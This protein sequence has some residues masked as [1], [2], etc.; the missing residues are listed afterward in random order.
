MSEKTEGLSAGHVGRDVVY[1][2][3]YPGGAVAERIVR[4]V[5]ELPDRTSP[6]NWPE[7]MLVTSDELR[8][9]VAEETSGDPPDAVAALRML[10][11]ELQKVLDM[12]AIGLPL[13]RAVMQAQDVLDRN[14]GRRLELNIIPEWVKRAAEREP[15]SGIVSA[16]GVYSRPPSQTCHNCGGPTTNFGDQS[17]GIILCDSCKESPR[18]GESAGSDPIRFG[19]VVYPPGPPQPKPA[20]PKCGVPMNFVDGGAPEHDVKV[21]HWRCEVWVGRGVCGAT[22]LEGSEAR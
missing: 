3:P 22:R 13:T 17:A 15:E 4:R 20:C 16:G 19:R 9:I 8:T 12:D 10:M 14:V 5:A 21:P 18:K 7:A 11:D 6:D 1:E 2:L